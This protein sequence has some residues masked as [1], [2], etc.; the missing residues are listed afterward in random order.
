MRVGTF[1][2][3]VPVARE[4][5]GVALR[6][7]KASD[8]IDDTASGAMT[9]EAAISGTTTGARQLWVGYVELPPGVQSAV[10]HHGE[11]ETAIYVIGGRARFASGDNLGDIQDAIAGDFVWVGPHDLHVEINLSDTEPVRMVV[12]RSTQEAIVVNVA[13]PEGWSPPT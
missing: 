6:V 4:E 8:R 10:H 11:S 7:I 3:S 12:A 13:P 2:A 5:S 9:R 1:L